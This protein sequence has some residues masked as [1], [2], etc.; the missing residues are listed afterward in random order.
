MWVKNK[1]LKNPTCR[2]IKIRIFLKMRNIFLFN[3]CGRDN[4]SVGWSVLLS[5]WMT[6]SLTCAKLQM[7]FTFCICDSIKKTKGFRFKHNHSIQIW[8]FHH[9][10]WLKHFCPEL[11]KRS[12]DLEV[13]L[14]IGGAWGPR[15]NTSSFQMFFS[16][17]GRMVVWKNWEKAILKFGISTLT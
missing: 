6:P 15:L 4:L 8:G 1:N 7:K 14:V 10:Q 2:E 11:W 13:R 12:H 16:L 9:F 5:N 3:F 17:L